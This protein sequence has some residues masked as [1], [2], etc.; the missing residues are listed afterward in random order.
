M[1]QLQ[2]F[3]QSLLS[4]PAAVARVQ[5]A[6]EKVS[7]SPGSVHPM[8]EV[9]RPSFKQSG[10]SVMPRSVVDI[11]KSSLAGGP[12]PGGMGLARQETLP[13]N[14]PPSV[15]GSGDKARFNP[16][17]SRPGAWDELA[18]GLHPDAV[19]GRDFQEWGR[20]EP[21]PYS[22]IKN[23]YGVIPGLEEVTQHEDFPGSI[24]E[25]RNK[26]ESRLR[27][28]LPGPEISDLE[29]WRTGGA[30]GTPY[31]T[32][33][34][35]LAPYERGNNPEFWDQVH[36]RPRI[37]DIPRD[38]S[39]DARPV[40]KILKGL[41]GEVQGRSSQEPRVSPWASE[42]FDPTVGP[43][44][45]KPYGRF[46]GTPGEEVA[47]FL[48]FPGGSEGGAE[49]IK[50]WKQGLG[51]LAK[52]GRWT[53]PGPMGVGGMATGAV[54][55]ALWAL[56]N[57]IQEGRGWDKIIPDVLT[58]GGIGAGTAKLL[59]YLEEGGAGSLRSLGG[60]VLRKGLLG[61]SGA[62]AADSFAELLEGGTNPNSGLRDH[63]WASGLG[64]LA[65]LTPTGRAASMGWG[66][67]SM[68]EPLVRTPVLAAE[69]LGLSNHYG[70]EQANTAPRHDPRPVVVDALSTLIRE[71][72]VE[73]MKQHIPQL[74]VT[75][76]KEATNAMLASAYDQTQG[77]QGRSHGA[78]RVGVRSDSPRFESSLSDIMPD[79]FR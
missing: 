44:E 49:G 69:K 12:T 72:G 63:P 35:A 7:S 51:S 17:Y 75:Y 46:T 4:D 42:P 24:L 48:G 8:S 57:D 39:L 54:G 65:S 55:P 34:K 78:P 19:Q 14:E 18:P 64:A 52:G 1:D 77:G 56:F 3:I 28:L 40:S 30:P 15:I 11:L 9:P 74:I 70:V 2:S 38:A 45:P 61:L 33:T 36:L 32:D 76:G 50:A 5:K 62:N 60:N 6:M 58:M 37:V 22:P 23:S 41:P 25:R 27:G 10:F 66:L 26:S 16:G 68:A 71:K 67:G 31:G 29:G 21:G 43:P 47:R 59:N 73:A 79:R 13:P 20:A 53:N